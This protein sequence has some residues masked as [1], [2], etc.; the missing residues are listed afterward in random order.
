MG[1]EDFGGDGTGGFIF[2]VDAGGEGSVAVARA[3]CFF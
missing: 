1:A 3:T 2:V